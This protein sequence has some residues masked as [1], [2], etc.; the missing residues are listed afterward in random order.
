MSCWYDQLFFRFRK[1]DLS[2]L[3]PLDNSLRHRLQ[4]DDHPS[5]TRG[6]KLSEGRLLFRL[7]MI[8]TLLFMAAIISTTRINRL[9]PQVI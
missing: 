1:V 9:P 6:S 7:C 8:V 3:A 2:F 5:R 4:L